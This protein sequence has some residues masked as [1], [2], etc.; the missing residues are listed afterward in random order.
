MAEPV[1]AVAPVTP[2]PFARTKADN[3]AVVAMFAPF[4]DTPAVA[5]LQTEVLTDPGLTVDTIRAKLLDTVGAQSK[6]VAHTP[7]IEHVSDER[8]KLREAA[9]QALLVRSGVVKSSERNQF[10]G[11]GAY[12]IAVSCL[13]KIGVKSEFDKE[14]NVMAALTSS[15]SDF[16]IILENVMHKSLQAGYDLQEYTWSRFCKRGSLSDLRPHGR[17]RMSSLGTLDPVNELGE[18]VNKSILDGEKSTIQGSTKGNMINVSA[19]MIINDDLGAFVGLA[20][21]LGRSAAGTVEQ[22]VFALLALNSGLGPLMWDGKTLF[23]ADH[24]NIGTGSALSIAAIDADRVLMARQ[25]DV[26]SNNFLRIR[27]SVLLVPTELGG[28]AREINSAEFNDE[29]QKN[30]RRPNTTRGLFSDIVDTPDLSGTRRYLFANPMLAPVIEVAFLNGQDGPDLRMEDGF[31]VDGTRWR[32][33]MRYG[34]AA[35]DYRGALTNAGA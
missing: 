3:A 16:P 1:Q 9:V 21:R 26:G 14:R 27:P 8:D 4:A 25:K 19:E 10:S 28:T 7:R 31:D 24:G 29:S 15:T 22:D 2:A 13:Q 17:Y 11:A 12:D 30:Q 33:R 34:V 18:F 23:H 32:V 20:N 5:A 6:P 35:I